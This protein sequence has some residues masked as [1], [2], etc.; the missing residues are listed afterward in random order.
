MAVREVLDVVKTRA[1]KVLGGVRLPNPA[2]IARW[3][4]R[5]ETVRRLRPF[6]AV[7]AEIFRANFAGKRHKKGP[8]E[9]QSG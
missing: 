7:D 6:L 1:R 3:R 4:A 8:G 9:I 5:I 2:P